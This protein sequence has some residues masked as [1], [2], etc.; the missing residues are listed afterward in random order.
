MVEC[1]FSPFA[2]MDVYRLP[3]LSVALLETTSIDCL[4]SVQI[5]FLQEH[6]YEVEWLGCT[7]SPIIL[8]ET[9]TSYT[10]SN[11]H[12]AGFVLPITSYLY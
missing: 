9:G 5:T 7:F 10:K 12:R 8:S 1:A 2:C 3:T 6:I 4:L 11:D